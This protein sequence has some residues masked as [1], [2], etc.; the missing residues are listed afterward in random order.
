VR[1]PSQ[2]Q[3]QT[4]TRL[5]PSAAAGRRW[6]TVTVIMTPSQ[7]FKLTQAD[8]GSEYKP[9][10]EPERRSDCQDSGGSKPL[11]GLNRDWAGPEL[12][13]ALATV[14]VTGAAC[15]AG[16]GAGAAAAAVHRRTLTPSR[17]PS[18]SGWHW[19]AGTQAP[20]PSLSLSTDSETPAVS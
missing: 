15:C 7:W 5:G 8:S 4:V 19:Q 2:N 3:P 20:G 17:T 12:A 16:R 6:V 11:R 13:S 18:P 10:S 9:A 14:T 1:T